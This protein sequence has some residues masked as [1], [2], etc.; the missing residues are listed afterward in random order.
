ME[1]S[2]ETSRAILHKDLPLYPYRV[3]AVQELLSADF[4]Q[5]LQFCE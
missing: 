1:V 5:R 3:T 4:P 2:L